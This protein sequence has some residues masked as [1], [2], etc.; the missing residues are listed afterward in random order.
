M[1]II[2]EWLI[3]LGNVKYLYICTLKELSYVKRKPSYQIIVKYFGESDPLVKLNTY[4]TSFIHQNILGKQFTLQDMQMI[5]LPY[6]TEKK[7]GCSV[8]TYVECPSLKV[9]IVLNRCLH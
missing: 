2:Q 5:R 7:A 1:K 8:E 4:Q 6:I 9:C 3:G